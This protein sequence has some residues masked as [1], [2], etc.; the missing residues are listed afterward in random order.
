M[1]RKR[2]LV[3]Y[4]FRLPSAMDNR[5]LRWEEFLERTGQ[6]VYLSATPGKYELSRGKG[7]VEQIIRPTGLVDPQVV[8]KPTKGQIDDLLHEIRAAHRQGRARPGDDADQE[9]GRGPHR[10]LPRPGRPGALP[11]LRHRHPAPGGAAAGAAPGRVRRPRRHQPAARGPRPAGG[12]AGRDPRRRQGGLP[13]LGD[14]ADPDHRPR[15]AQRVGR[16]PHVRR[17][18]HPLDGPGHR[19]DEP[20]PREAGRLQPREGRRPDAAAQADRGHH[21]PHRPRGRRH[22]RA[23]GRRAGGQRPLAL[24]GE[25]P[26]AGRWAARP[27]TGGRGPLPARGCRRPT[28]PSSSRSS[29]TRCT[30]A[31]AELQFELAARLRDEVGDLKKELR[32]MRAAQGA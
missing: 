23:A 1:S 32:G 24:A 25:G 30:A 5:P 28:S 7:V 11:A 2:T 20:P 12:V 8:V 9:D 19:R 29:P 15:G 22:R 4:G 31:A 26:D 14:L 21:R 3:D 27:R 18:D 17:P 13:A 6:T 10:L 16:G